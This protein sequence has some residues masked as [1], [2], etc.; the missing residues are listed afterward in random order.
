MPDKVDAREAAARARPRKL[1][2]DAHRPRRSQRCVAD[3]LIARLHDA[4]NAE[5]T[6]T[7]TQS[8]SG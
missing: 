5:R 1:L 7:A 6:L 3:A 8:P 2:R 4:A